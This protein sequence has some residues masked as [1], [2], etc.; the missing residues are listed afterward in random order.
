MG[1]I[2]MPSSCAM[3]SEIS[4]VLSVTILM[5]AMLPAPLCFRDWTR[6]NTL[7]YHDKIGMVTKGLD[8]CGSMVISFLFVGGLCLC[9]MGT[10]T[11]HQQKGDRVPLRITSS[12]K[13]KSIAVWARTLGVIPPR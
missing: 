4:E 8:A 3:P 9:P 12:V 10:G 13:R 5:R 6:R 11:N 1:T 7:N 2:S